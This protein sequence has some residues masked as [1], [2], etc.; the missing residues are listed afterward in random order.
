MPPFFWR[1]VAR[2]NPTVTTVFLLHPRSGSAGGRD[3]VE[4]IEGLLSGSDELQ[5]TA[6]QIRRTFEDGNDATIAKAFG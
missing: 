3:C 1:D 5:I 4:V 2:I 6:S